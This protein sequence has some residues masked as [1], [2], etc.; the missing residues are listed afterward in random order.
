V[1]QPNTS[2][3]AEAVGEGFSPVGRWKKHFEPG[4]LTIFEELLGDALP[5][6]G[7]PMETKADKK[8]RVGL[9]ML[10]AQYRAFFDAK[11]FLRTRTPLGRLLVTRDLS[12]L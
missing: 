4:E 8:R 11:L 2:F 6:F 7:Y 10:R 5:E 12:R 3:K 9:R 1:S